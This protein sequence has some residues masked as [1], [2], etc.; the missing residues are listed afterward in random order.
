MFKSASGM[1]IFDSIFKQTLGSTDHKYHHPAHPTIQTI[2]HM[3]N[4]TV[5]VLRRQVQRPVVPLRTIVRLCTGLQQQT[6]HV[7]VAPRRGQ[8]ECRVGLIVYCRDEQPGIKQQPA[9]TSQ[10]GGGGRS[11][12]TRKVAAAGLLYAKTNTGQ[13]DRMTGCKG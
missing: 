8:V 2:T 10:G 4:G 11:T 13:D 9:P 6:N 3:N 1:L 7:R 5:P 12:Q